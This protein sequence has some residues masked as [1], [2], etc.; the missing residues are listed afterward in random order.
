VLLFVGDDV[1]FYNAIAP[2]GD[3]C[4]HV[5]KPFPQQATTMGLQRLL[6]LD[7]LVD[8]LDLS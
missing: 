4:A 8:A 5:P 3:A 7:L 6:L 1:P 2:L